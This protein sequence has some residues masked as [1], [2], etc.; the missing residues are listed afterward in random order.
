MRVKTKKIMLR[1]SCLFALITTLASCGNG[2]LDVWD[3]MR[4]VG[5]SSA[6]QYGEIVAEAL[7][8]DQPKLK[9]PI[10][11]STGTGKGIEL[12]CS[13]IGGTSPDIVFASRRMKKKEHD[14]CLANGVTETIE[15]QIGMDGIVLAHAKDGPAL[16]LTSM[17]IYKAFAAIPFGFTNRAEKWNQINSGL[18]ALPIQLYGPGSTSGTRTGFA[19]LIM[20]PACKSDPRIAAIKDQDSIKKTCTEL[21][22]DGHYTLTEETDELILHKLKTNK[23]AIGI[24]PFAFAEKHSD[25]IKPLTINGI[26]PTTS[27][28]LDETFPG[29]RRVYVYV[30][31]AHLD[32]VPGLKDYVMQLQ[33]ESG[34]DGMLPK[35]GLIPISET[36]RAKSADIVKT[37]RTMDLAGLK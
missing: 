20:A 35:A 9:P 11:E 28:I 16:Q 1:S 19:D 8:I 18:P 27:T 37:W 32:A 6:Q 12:F 34:P 2:K 10:I 29:A 4:I 17:D 31:R 33:A 15:F 23:N 3:Q 30:K 22:D 25:L 7:L 36:E 24:V 5:S 14:A 21:R 26:T 13:A